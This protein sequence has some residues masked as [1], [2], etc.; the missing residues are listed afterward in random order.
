MSVFFIDTVDIIPAGQ[1]DE[2]LVAEDG[3][4]A[5]MN[6]YEGFTAQIVHHAY[7]LGNVNS[8]PTDDYHRLEKLR[9]KLDQTWGNKS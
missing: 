2:H 1:D 3:P 5:G 6:L 4:H 8:I 9:Q 7:Q